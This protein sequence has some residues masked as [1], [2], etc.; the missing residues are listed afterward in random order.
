MLLYP[1]AQ[2]KGQQYID[3]NVGGD[4][5]PTMEDESKLHYVQCLVKETLRWMPT[6]PLGAVP[7][8]TTQDDTYRDFIIPKGAGVVP[9]IWAI[10]MDPTRSPNPRKF[11]PERYKDDHLH[12]YDSAV[13]PDVTKRDNFSFGAGRRLCQGMH[14]AERSLFLA[15]S[16]ILWAFD[17]RPAVD[18]KGQE[19]MPEQEKLTQGF[20]F[21]PEPYKARITVRSPEK[22][23]I[24]RREWESAE[25]L[26]DPETKQWM[27]SPVKA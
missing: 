10:N 3:E 25:K 19:I 24:V 17:I 9:N 14:V 1:E 11:D 16:R 6:A 13:N 23:E 26:L 18:E 15:V 21:M 4:R 8:A 22:A 2:R 7:H 5:L 12:L 27:V 20:V